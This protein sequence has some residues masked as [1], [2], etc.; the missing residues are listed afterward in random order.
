MDDEGE[1]EIHTTSDE[2]ERTDFTILLLKEREQF[3]VVI[4]SHLF[5]VLV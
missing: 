3:E 1:N 5:C 4:Q 2:I